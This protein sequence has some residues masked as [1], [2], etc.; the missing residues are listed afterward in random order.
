M[1]LHLGTLWSGADQLLDVIDQCSWAFDKCCSGVK[2][3]LAD[4][5]TGNSVSFHGDAE[6][7]WKKAGIKVSLC[8]PRV[9]PFLTVS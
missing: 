2:N 1:I 5:R 3:C 4:T 8:H 9:V 7:Q 6:R